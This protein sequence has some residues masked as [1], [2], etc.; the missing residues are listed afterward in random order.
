[1]ILVLRG[2]I[3][4][5]FETPDLLHFVK[6]LHTM[7]V[8][9]NTSLKIYIHTWNIVSNSISWRPIAS[10]NTAV[11][12]EM[13]LLYFQDV[14]HIIQTILI[15]DDKKIVL[16]GNVYGTI[17]GG[18]MP[19][20]GWKNYWYGKYRIMT[21]ILEQAFQK[22]VDEHEVL[23]NCRFDILKNSNTYT[24]KTLLQFIQKH[25]NA[26]FQKN[27]F[28]E[29]NEKCGIDNIYIGN[30]HTMH[31]IAHHFFYNLDKILEKHKE[32]FNQEWMVFRENKT[33][34]YTFSH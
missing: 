26:N 30:I 28:T 5:S 6:F 27:I 20:I 11:T 31:R 4:D 7:N 15:E 9:K 22:E 2:H 16:H 24:K 18:P 34:F 33:L 1:M 12:K 8:N 19:I 14:S 29:E 23:V 32:I 13:I 17:N 21:H 10:N 3:R 25:C